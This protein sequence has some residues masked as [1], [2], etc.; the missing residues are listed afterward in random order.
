MILD[1]RE[2]QVEGS[3][4]NSR[5]VFQTSVIFFRVT[6]SPAIFQTIINEILQNLINTGEVVNFIDNVIVETE[7]KEKYNKVVEKVIKRLVENDLYYK[8]TCSSRAFLFYIFQL[9]YVL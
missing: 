3:I 9:I 1:K 4:Y 8:K 2:R 6:N 5:G 7:K